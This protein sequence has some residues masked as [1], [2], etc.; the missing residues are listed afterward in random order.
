MNHIV[1]ILAWM[2][3]SQFGSGFLSA[4]LIPFRGCLVE[5]I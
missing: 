1:H 3:G 2:F 4:F 5:V